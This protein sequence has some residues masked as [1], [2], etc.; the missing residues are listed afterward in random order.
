MRDW[1]EYKKQSLLRLADAQKFREPARG[2][3]KPESACLRKHCLEVAPV[4]L[5]TVKLCPDMGEAS[6]IVSNLETLQASSSHTENGKE[7]L[8]RTPPNTTAN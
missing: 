4:L 1:E 6:S 5:P 2:S 3:P 8:D 7:E